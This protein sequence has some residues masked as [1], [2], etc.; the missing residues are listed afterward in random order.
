LRTGR[1]I[2]EG[3]RPE[4][5][6]PRAN[7]PAYEHLASAHGT[8]ADYLVYA[9]ARLAEYLAIGGQFTE[10]RT[11]GERFVANAPVER[12]AH[13]LPRRQQTALGNAWF[14]LHLSYAAQGE[15]DRSAHAAAEALRYYGAAQWDMMCGTVTRHALRGL[16]TYRTEEAAKRRRLAEDQD[17][18]YARW[19][20]TLGTTAEGFSQLPVWEVEGRWAE[21]R[22]I[23]SS[24]LRSFSDN[25]QALALLTLGTIARA[26]GDTETAWSVVR[27]RLPDGLTAPV[28]LTYV[29][30]E[31][32]LRLGASLALDAGNLAVARAW[33]EAHDALLAECEAVIGRS[34]AQV[35]WAVYSR[36]RGDAAQAHQHAERALACAMEPRQPLALVVAH[37]LLAELDTEAGRYADAEAHLDAALALADA[38]HAPYE[39]ALSLLVLAELWAASGDLRAAATVLTE[40]RAICEPLDAR[41]ALARA[42][43]LVARYPTLAPTRTPTY[44]AGLSAREV[45][46][47]RLVA[48]GMTNPQVAERLYLSPRTVEQHLRSIYNKLG[49]S[50][51]TAATRFAVEHQLT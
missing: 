12:D 38:C 31:P 4:E 40:A 5:R 32:R 9:D 24:P 41:P 23:A 51:R 3:L 45:D 44:P 28:S 19:Q 18:F 2:L 1:A 34:E 17:A 49:S 30:H 10:A 47:L 36:L 16:L 39:R 27:A 29:N 20:R 42:D 25:I 26:Q 33:L 8:L 21:A 13:L 15:P 22:A 7:D 43:A 46:V 48:Q 11:I 35:L 50:S 6:V 37:R 14:G